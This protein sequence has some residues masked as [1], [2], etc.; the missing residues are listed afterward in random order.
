MAKVILR[1]LLGIVAAVFLLAGAAVALN[2]TFN[3]PP[4]QVAKLNSIKQGT[5]REEVQSALGKPTNTY[6]ANRKW[7]Y[8]RPFGWSI[9]YIYFDEQG[10]F[11]KYEY[12]Y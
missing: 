3:R 8:S 11:E 10:R 5:T 4:V 7:A 2:W 12:D 9:V 6:E 1:I